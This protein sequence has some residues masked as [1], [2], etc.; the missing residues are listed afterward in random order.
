MRRFFLLAVLAVGFSARAEVL[1]TALI[2]RAGAASGSGVA[3]V[4]VWPTGNAPASWAVR[5]AV[6]GAVT[7]HR[8]VWQRVGE[9]AVLCFDASSGSLRYWVDALDTAAEPIA[10]QPQAGL[11]V[12]T[13]PRP[14]GLADTW[15]EA[16]AVWALG[17]VPSGRSFT[18]R[19]FG[20]VPPHG[21]AADFICRFDGWLRIDQAGEYAFATVS[22]DASFLSVDG[23]RVAAWPG[24]H[25]PEGGVLGE[26][27]GVIRLEPGV[28]RFEYLNVQFGPGYRVVAAWRKPGVR[29]FE[30]IPASAFVPTDSFEARA[31]SSKAA[32]A[33]VFAWVHEGYA[34]AGK[35]VLY[36]VRLWLPGGAE[37]KEVRWVFDDGLAAEGAEVRHVFVGERV[38]IVA[39]EVWQEGRLEGRISLPLRLQRA[40]GQIEESPEARLRPLL[41]A[42]TRPREIRKRSV[43]EL[44]PL[45]V[46][47]DTTDDPSLPEVAEVIVERRRECVGALAEGV[48]ALGFYFQRPGRRNA[49]YV[50]TLWT[51]VIEDRQ[52]P[53][54]LRAQASLHLA[55]FLIHSGA[56]IARGMRL[57]SEAARDEVLGDGDQRLKLIFTGDGRLMLGDRAAAIAAY[58]KAGRAVADDDTHYEVRRRVRLE[59]ARHFLN[60]KEYAAAEQAVRDLEWEWPMERVELE[61]GLLMMAIHRQ[62]GELDFALTAGKRLLAG[63]PADPARSD[64]LLALAE[65]QRELKQDEAFRLTLKQLQREYPYSEAAARAADRY[66]EK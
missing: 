36:D 8:V 64:L 35:T 17:G 7:P 41:R 26:R 40:P 34:V 56:G 5:D 49:A 61:T 43:G 15:E 45:F 18:D 12:E 54:G 21:L 19:V 24:Q 57:L 28:H 60:R 38:S 42:A 27:H 33:P 37:G 9:P 39:C 51:T 65:V 3:R 66:P 62:R 31:L 44:Y 30:V 1:Y 2:E 14:E 58:R 52:A 6:S 22:D 46:A 20:G 48:Y 47:A 50:E 32:V 13:R 29:A 11:T 55:G 16:L 25:G 23:N 59:A 4:T 63:A 53:E 10:W